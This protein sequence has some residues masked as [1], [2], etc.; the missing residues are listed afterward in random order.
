MRNALPLNMAQ[1]A[2]D[3][4]FDPT[5]PEHLNAKLQDFETLLRFVLLH[6]LSGLSLVQTCALAAAAKLPEVSAVALHKRLKKAH[7]WMAP[8]LKALVDQTHGFDQEQWAG[9][10]AIVVDATVCTKP[11]SKG[12]DARVH[13][14]LDLHDGTPTDLIVTDASGGETFRN[15]KPQPG[16]LFIA[17]RVYCN[18]PGIAH[19]HRHEAHALVRFN[20]GSIRLLDAHRKPMDVLKRIKGMEEGQVKDW[21]V[22]IPLPTDG[23]EP[24][25]L[26]ARL[27]VRRL[28]KAHKEEALKRLRKE[29]GSKIPKASRRSAG[30]IILLT[31]V[32]SSALSARALLRLYRLRWNVE[33]RIKADKSLGDLNELSVKRTDTIKAWLLGRLIGQQLFHRA[34]LSAFSP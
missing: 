10:R 16:Q 20:F 21:R 23:G 9:L 15:F 6:I 30:F 33:L 2:Q 31:T 32:A 19:L 7:T 4:G 13:Y 3:H 27:V 18:P 14:A 24:E 22:Y 29:Y 12:T 26:K 17:D 1:I 25:Q 34:L 11:A 28:S 5:P 8:I